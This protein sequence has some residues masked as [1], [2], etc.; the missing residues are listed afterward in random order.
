MAAGSR[1]A[2]VAA[3]GLFAGPFH[4][5]YVDDADEV[6]LA[7]RL[8]AEIGFGLDGTS[9]LPGVIGEVGTWGDVPTAAEERCLR[10]AARAA[11]Y[12]GLSVAAH[13]RPGL[14]L[15]E[16]L[17]G[18]GLA[19][20]RIAITRQDLSDDPAA[21]RKIAENGAYVSFSLLPSDPD[22]ATAPLET[23]IRPVLDLLDAGHADRVLLSSGVTRMTQITRY[24][25][26]GYAHLFNTVLPA[27][28]A[29]GA[30]DATLT[31]VLHRNPLAW[32][33]TAS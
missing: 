9:V 23:R 18:A 10:G 1:V 30:D 15:L 3:T 2:V 22:A 27:L 29:A 32:L 28:R 8:L 12:S 11:E 31:Q 7:E 33:T 13:G 14:A 6:K 19:P 26:P 16:V 20:G 24:D 21:L 17:T 5:S 25:G 4:P